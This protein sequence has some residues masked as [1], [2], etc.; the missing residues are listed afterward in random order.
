MKMELMDFKVTAENVDD[1]TFVPARETLNR[2]I[3]GSRHHY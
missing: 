1:R 2:K 3:I